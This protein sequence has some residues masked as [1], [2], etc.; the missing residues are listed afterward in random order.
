MRSW[1][2]CENTERPLSQEITL[3]NWVWLKE[4]HLVLKEVFFPCTY[5]PH[6]SDN[7]AADMFQ[8][9]QLRTVKLFT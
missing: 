6:I 4:D 8:H 7:V 5:Q 2:K 1:E 9:S 3:E